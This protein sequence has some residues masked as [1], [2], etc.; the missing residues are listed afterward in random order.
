MN[1][2]DSYDDFQEDYS[3]VGSFIWE[4]I[5]I[6]TL[7]LV[8]IVPIRVFLFQPFFVQGASMEPNFENKEYLIVNEFGY[9]RTVAAVDGFHIFTLNPFKQLERQS[10][11]V[12][13]YPKDRRQFF[14]KRVIG[15]PGEKVQVKDGNV[16]IYNKE[17][18]DGLMLDEKNY[19]S[20]NV[21]TTGENIVALKEDE[22]FVLGDNRMFSSDSRSW[23][24]IKASDVI[25][26]TLIRA[27]PLDRLSVF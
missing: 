15:L 5:K 12:F 6:F 2:R 17:N 14:I 13:R 16:T 25:G 21:K 18:P 7:A 8:I 23:G 22:Y 9:K 19:L 26:K 10:V 3:G 11:I 1:E 4:I 20:N 24:P 27:W